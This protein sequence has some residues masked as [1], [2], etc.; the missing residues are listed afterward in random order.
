MSAHPEPLVRARPS[1]PSETPRTAASLIK[2]AT[3]LGWE[4]SCTYAHGTTFDA[5]GRPSHLVES[6]IL[7]LW[8]RDGGARAVAIWSNG[9]FDVAF[10]WAAWREL[11]RV[12]ARAVPAWLTQ[13]HEL[14]GGLT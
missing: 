12:G 13:V 8:H 5:Q 6:V 11:D 7:R 2:K 9:K 3:S 10:T 1:L 14:A 4:S